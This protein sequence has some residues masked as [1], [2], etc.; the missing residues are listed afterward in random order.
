MR[1]DSRGKVGEALL[2]FQMPLAFGLKARVANGDGGLL[3]E[4]Q[5]GNHILFPN[6]PVG[7]HVV[8]RQHAD[9][10]AAGSQREHAMRDGLA[11]SAGRRLVYRKPLV[12][13]VS[14]LSGDESVDTRP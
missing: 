7:E 12:D 5:K 1:R 9:E 11:R 10:L 4:G 2:S 13:I 3:R 6:T 14:L 8:Y